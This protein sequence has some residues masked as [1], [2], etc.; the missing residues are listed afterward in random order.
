MSHAA[1]ARLRQP[2]SPALTRPS[3]AGANAAA[4]ALSMRLLRH[5]TKNALQRIIAQVANAELRATPA[6]NTLADEIEQRI[7]LSARISDTLFGLTETPGPL[8][9]RLSSL[10]HAV[11]EL[12]A[13][14]VQTI[15]T[16]VQIAGRCP[17]SLT[18]IV[19]QTTHEMVTNAVKHGL[20][21]RLVG[22]IAVTLEID[23]LVSR[24]GGLTLAVRD[25]GWGPDKPGFNEGLA[26][27][28]LMAKQH[29]GT[30]QLVRELGW[31]VS[32]LRIPHQQHA[33]HRRVGKQQHQHPAPVP[34]SGP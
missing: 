16:S 2:P 18:A 6:G 31:T 20:H 23:R 27:L 12:M 3:Q 24:L 17:A 4:E 32:R 26:V 9:K 22:E 21:M 15:Q 14:P 30:V 13:D 28:E 8:D 7:R 19:V 5:H 10:C 25:N 11:V 34:R 1:I 29:G 33:G